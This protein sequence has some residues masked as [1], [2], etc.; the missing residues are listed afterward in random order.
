[1]K[2]ILF[3]LFVAVAALVLVGCKTPEN[4][5]DGAITEEVKIITPQGNPFIAV[6]NLLGEENIKI[7]SVN[8]AAGVK[9]ALVAG[10]YDIVIAPLNLG[11]QLYSKEQSKYVLNSVIALGNTYIV[12]N[13]N[14]KLDSIQ[15]LQGKTILAYSQGGTPD[16]VLQ[17]VLNANNV[18]ATIE[19]QP[20]ITEV[21]PF[22][23]Q[24][25]YDYILAAEPVITNLKVKKNKELNVLNLQDY[26][27]NT[28]MQAAVFVNPNSQKQESIKAVISKIEAN[29]KQ[30]NENPQAYANSIIS[31]DVY[32]SDLGADIIATSLPNANLSFLDAKNNKSKIEAYL[33]MIGYQLPNEGFYQ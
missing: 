2:K 17:Y 25:Q 8:G 19:Y 1:M 10:E 27:D 9:Q 26:T 3:M 22:F 31:K 23:M 4:S 24:G 30:M 21:V 12:S 6:G 15:D 5:G 29:I 14:V 20:S 32:F 18:Q 16:I 11:A 28:I 13:K 7:D 33:T